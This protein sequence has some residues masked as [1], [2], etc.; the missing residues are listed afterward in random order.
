MDQKPTRLTDLD[1][2]NDFEGCTFFMSEDYSFNR[3]AKVKADG[4]VSSGGE[5]NRIIT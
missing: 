4:P 2:E 1:A 3:R 5:K